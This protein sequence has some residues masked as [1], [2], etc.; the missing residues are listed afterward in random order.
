MLSCHLKNKIFVYLVN[1]K[2]EYNKSI[3]YIENFVNS[4]D[5]KYFKLKDIF[6]E[7]GKNIFYKKVKWYLLHYFFDSKNILYN[8]LWIDDNDGTEICSIKFT[9][10]QAILNLEKNDYLFSNYNY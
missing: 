8:F 1:W 6:F 9:F 3:S 4:N 2:I 7:S 10:I 5:N